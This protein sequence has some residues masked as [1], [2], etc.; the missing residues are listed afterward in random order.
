MSFVINTTIDKNKEFLDALR[1]S[2][3]RDLEKDVFLICKNVKI[4][5]NSYALALA[6]DFFKLLLKDSIGKRETIN[7]MVPD[8]RPE[9]LKKVVEYIYIGCISLET[10]YMGGK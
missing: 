4:P 7:I 6:S 3:H 5:I 1:D 2:Y 8:V 10:R 9:V